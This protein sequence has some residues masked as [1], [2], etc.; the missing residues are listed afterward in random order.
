MPIGTG[1]I[2]VRDREDVKEIE[3]LRGVLHHIGAMVFINRD[4]NI[5][6]KPDYSPEDMLNAVNAVLGDT[7][8]QDL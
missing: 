8:I 5:R 3:R 4:G 2:E 6:F 1:K 7:V